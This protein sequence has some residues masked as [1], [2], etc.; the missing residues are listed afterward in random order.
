MENVIG[1]I[2]NGFLKICLIDKVDSLNAVAVEEEMNKIEAENSNLPILV[3]CEKLNYISSAGLR[4]MLRLKKAHNEMKIIN[5]S[6]EVYDIFEMTGFTTIMTVEKAYKVLNVEGCPIIGRGANG[7]VY[8]YDPETVVKVYKNADSLDEIKHEREVARKALILGIPTAISYDIV[9][10]GDSYASVFELINAKSLTNILA[11][12]P[13]RISELVDIYVKLLHQIH[14]T[15]VPEGTLPKQ[16]DVFVKWAA[17]LKGHLPDDIHAKLTQLI[18][19]IPE[20][21]HMVHGDCHTKNIMLQGDEV[22]LIDMDTLC[23]GNPVFEFAPI[24]LAY[25]G[26]G[27]VDHEKVTKF[28]DMSWEQAQYI[29]N[30]TIKRYFKVDD[31]TPYMDRIRLLGFTR[32]LERVYRKDK[33]NV[34]LIEF[35][36]KQIIDLVN[37]LDKV[38]F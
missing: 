25:N 11:E 17:N 36:Q 6:V 24:F 38:Y 34:K 7:I 35:S 30:E 5:T 23:V 18:A 10:V 9:K 16:K 19:D 21:N 32:L 33:D 8:R 29:L 3:D 14:E 12:E 27:A 13:D 4:I 20:D 22:I 31:P 37:K 26:F 2:E 15:V 1:K 28:I